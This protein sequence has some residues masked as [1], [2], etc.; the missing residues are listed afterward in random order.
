MPTSDPIAL[1]ELPISFG[2]HC[3]DDSV[4]TMREPGYTADQMLAYGKACVDAAHPIPAD[5]VLVPRRATPEMLADFWYTAT[6]STGGGFW[7]TKRQLARARKAYAAMLA[8]APPLNELLGQ[9]EEFNLNEVSGNSGQLASLEQRAL[10]A[11]LPP[12]FT[13]LTASPGHRSDAAANIR[14]LAEDVGAYDEPAGIVPSP[15]QARLLADIADAIEADTL[16]H[17]NAALSAQ[18]RDAVAVAAEREQW[19]SLFQREGDHSGPAQINPEKLKTW[20]RRLTE[21]AQARGAEVYQCPRCATSMEVDPTAKPSGVEG[22]CSR[23]DGTGD[24]HRAD[25]EYV[26]ACDCTPPPGV[27]VGKLRGLAKW[28]RARADGGWTGKHQPVTASTLRIWAGTI[29]A[30]IAIIDAA[31]PGVQS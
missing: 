29:D 4:R 27:D 21:A 30:A 13:W 15:T 26:G 16:F 3:V 25:G 20:A 23:C 24:I 17:R 2:E 10:E 31:A 22:R 11:E 1:P 14:Q 12:G 19:A 6:G 28:M 7:L 18:P 5:M 8:A 9:P